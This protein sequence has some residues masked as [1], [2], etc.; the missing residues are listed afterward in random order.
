MPEEKDILRVLSAEE[1]R[2]NNLVT[3]NLKQEAL[4]FPGRKELLLSGKC[5]ALMPLNM[6]TDGNMERGVTTFPVTEK[7]LQ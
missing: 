4:D 1:E 5:S 7:S 2:M 6:V 3:V